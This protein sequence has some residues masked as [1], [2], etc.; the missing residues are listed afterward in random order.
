MSLSGALK[1]GVSVAVT[2]SAKL[3]SQETV[4]LGSPPLPA[5]SGP[6]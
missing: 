1:D 4:F 3:S 6:C 2:S 5:G